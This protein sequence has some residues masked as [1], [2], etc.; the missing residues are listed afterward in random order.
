MTNLPAAIETNT[1]P[2]ISEWNTIQQIAGALVKSGF[3]PPAIKT[4]EAATAIILKG[5]EL[6]IPPMQSFSHIHIIQGRPTCSSELMLALLAR[7]GV[8]WE[9]VA[10]GTEEEA[11]IEFRRQGFA[12]VKGIYTLKEAQLAKLTGKETWRAYQANMLRARAISN[13]A[14]MIGPD[15]LAGMSYT[16]EEMGAEVNE[17]GAPM[18]NGRSP[19]VPALVETVDTT[20]GEISQPEPPQAVEQ[21]SA[22]AASTVTPVT[23]EQIAAGIEALRRD[24]PSED[25]EETIRWAESNQSNPE[26]LTILRSK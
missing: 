26:V 13:G 15:L 22:P 23:P 3:L 5:R 21:A 9:W 14:R 16:P 8:T 12:N 4:A 24:W 1:I 11:I 10:D 7:G 6:A 25:T 20:T 19:V 2:A 18:V 17:D